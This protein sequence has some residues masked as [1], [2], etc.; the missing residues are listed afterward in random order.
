[1]DV[2]QKYAMHK[3]HNLHTLDYLVLSMNV[4]QKY[5]MQECNAWTTEHLYTIRPLF[6]LRPCKINVY[7]LY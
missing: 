5:T 4:L 1:M 6:I 2:L 7:Q 3:L